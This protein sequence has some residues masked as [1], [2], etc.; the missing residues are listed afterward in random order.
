MSIRDLIWV[1]AAQAIRQKAENEAR[2]QLE[3]SRFKMLGNLYMAICDCRAIALDTNTCARAQVMKDLK[4]LD[5]ENLPSNE[6]ERRER[7]AKM[8]PEELHEQ[9]IK[10]FMSGKIIQG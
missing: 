3:E 4:V 1:N 6:A 10:D 2:H 7:L 5:V 8:T 9:R